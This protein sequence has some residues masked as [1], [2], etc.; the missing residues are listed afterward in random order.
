MVDKIAQDYAGKPVLFIEADVSRS[1]ANRASRWWSAYGQG[2]S[3][4]TPFETV[5]SGWKISNGSEKFEQKFKS[6]VDDALKQPAKAEMDARYFRQGS[7][8]TAKINLTNRSGVTLGPTNRAEVILLVYE[9]FHFRDTSRWSRAGASQRLTTPLADGA[10]ASFEL[11][12]P[13]IA[14]SQTNMSKIHVVAIAD[15]KPDPAK[16][17]FAMLQSAVALIGAAPTTTPFPTI[18]LPTDEPEPTALPTINFPTIEPVMPT[19]APTDPPAPTQRWWSFL[20]SAE[21]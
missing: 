13:A 3:A 4:T 6:M 1:P 21:R 16:G 20:P 10:S 17:A 11:M 19:A 12:I 18:A 9:D 7:S 15:Y 5:D 8:V 14:L 2:G